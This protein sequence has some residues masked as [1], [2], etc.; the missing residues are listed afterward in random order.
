MRISLAVLWFL[1]ASLVNAQPPTD[2]ATV[3][4]APPRVSQVEAGRQ[5]EQ[6]VTLAN[7]QADYTLCYDIVELK[8]DPG[9]VGSTKWVFTIDYIPLG[10]PG[11]S[12][13]G[14]Y[15][16]GFIQWTFDGEGIKEYPARFRVVHASGPDAMVEYV[17]DTPKV[18]ATARFALTAGSDKLLFFGRY[19]PK[20]E[21][22]ESKL[23][24][25]CYPATF[26]K[27]WER[28][29]TTA[30]RTVDQGGGLP[31]DLVREK[32]VLFED[33][34]EGRPAGGSSGLLLGDTS[35]FSQVTVEAGGYAEYADL[36]L[37]PGRR[38]FALGLYDYPTLPDWRVTREYFG[39]LADRECEAIAALAQGDLD[40]PL[41]PLPVDPERAR[42]IARRDE[43]KLSRPAETWRPAAEP[44]P[45]PWAASLPDG[46]VKAALLCARWSAYET[47]ELA[48]RL[49]LDVEHLYLDGKGTLSH[50]DYWPYAGQ[51][52]IGTLGAGLAERQAVRVCGDATH[53]VILV[54]GVNSAV[55]TDRIRDAILAQVRSG[56]GL[57]LS[58]DGGVLGGWPEELT[59]APDESLVAP[60]LASMPWE[61]FPGL[62]PGERGRL[63]GPCLQGYRYGE[64]RVIVFR[65]RL[66]EYSSLIP[67]N[68]AIEGLDGA[69]DHILA[70]QA[71]AVLAAAGRP[72]AVD[73][74]LSIADEAG[75]PAVSVGGSLPADATYRMRAIDEWDGVHDVELP[76]NARPAAVRLDYPVGRNCFV[77]LVALN[78]AGECLGYATAF[79]PVTGAARIESVTLSPGGRSHPDVPAYV[80]LVRGGRLR[81]AAELSGLE[82]L[83]NL[84]LRAEVTDCF[85][86]EVA[87]DSVRVDGKRVLLDLDFPAPVAVSHCLDLTLVSGDRPVAVRRERFTVPLPY[88]YD[89]FTLLL[90]TYAG[91]EPA[92]RQT[93]RRCYELGTEMADLCHMGGYADQAAAREYAVAA[94]SGL[95]LVPY[96]TRLAGEANGTVRVPCLQDPQY[97]QSTAA[98][99]ANTCRHAAP[100]APAAYTLGDENYLCQGPTD[101][102]SSPETTADFRRWLA[103]KYGA[104]AKLNEVWRMTYADFADI[105]GPTTLDQAAEQTGSFA[106]WF[107]HRR[108]MDSAFATAHELFAGVVRQEDPGAKVGW[109]GLLGNHWLAGYDFWKLSRRL[110]LNQVYTASWPQGEFVRSFAQPGAVTGEWG[111]AIADNEAGFSA[112]PWHN[113][114]QGYNSC[115]WWTSWGCDYIPFNPDLSVNDFGKW[116]FAAGEEVRSGPGRLLLH[117]QRDNSGIAVWYSQTDMFAAKLMTRFSPA[118]PFAG[119]D[120]FWADHA[121]LLHALE[122]LGY[123]YEHVAADDVETRGVEALS[124]YRVLCLPFATCLSDRQVAAL[125]A[126]VEGGG[127][128]IADGRAG[129]LTGDGAIRKERPLDDV[130]GVRSPAGLEAL[131]AGSQIV[132]F[133]IATDETI[134]AH[135]LEPE[136]AEAGGEADDDIEGM[137]GSVVHQFGAGATL[138]LNFPFRTF[139]DARSVDPTWLP[140][141]IPDDMIR[142]TAPPVVEV[143]NAEG[144]RPAYIEQ[145]LYRDGDLQ[146]LALERDIHNRTPDVQ[147]VTVRLRDGARY[148][149]DVRDGEQVGTEAT[150]S[151]QADVSRGKPRLFALLPYRVTELRT[152]LPATIRRGQTLE[153]GASLRVAPGTPQFHVVHLSVFPPGSDRQHRQ[154]SRNIDCPQ[155][156]GGASI[157]FALNDPP[158]EWTLRLR[159]VASGETT[160]KV[161]T[162]R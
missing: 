85:G 8:D 64:G 116:F 73:V 31:L 162:V 12:Q 14:W 6:N 38:S 41:T 82:G 9:K 152:N 70:L 121:A 10:L 42:L 77:D 25:M 68:D 159:D 40:Q 71:K 154:Y 146:Y 135:M 141:T 90:W 58:G 150:A 49:E 92:I 126:F 27:P 39:R 102:C 17:W 29:V 151:W 34:A 44:A 24:L 140:G 139:A 112:I 22:K 69:T 2:W 36:T 93:Q 145:V 79:V 48:R 3:T 4:V 113:L 84:T 28:C 131:K 83:A 81:C 55:L 1:A 30:V 157:P 125:R 86:R 156:R 26:E 43:Q 75:T 89:D 46:P 50:T 120:N 63:E 60:I 76:A 161:L 134:D 130:F 100:Y 56:K 97:L 78:R 65:A 109:D 133:A 7:A 32:W 155:G 67:L 35:A 23:R 20:G 114:F 94:E 13:A 136:L 18:T 15:W 137:L 21:V 59:A 37:A 33:V 5:V 115:W 144:I 101:V 160:T 148:V 124:G 66:G 158:G 98:S 108:H 132:D 72:L 129:L 91:G 119:E 47:M 117:A 153:V 16:Q 118:A 128:L 104:I 51:T 57:F 123:Q 87:T 52:G 142:R 147:A 95:R 149:Y 110:E 127:T 99:I 111:N 11:P 106:P 54:A 138:Y 61:E 107:D 74:R 45:F 103:E 88:P 96:V 19:E 53:E 143:G 105:A 80:D 122:D 62:R